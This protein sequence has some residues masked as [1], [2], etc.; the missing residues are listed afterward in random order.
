[1]NNVSGIDY[2][3]INSGAMGG[4]SGIYPSAAL[5]LVGNLGVGGM[6]GCGGGGMFGGG[7]GGCGI[8]ELIIIM[9]L[10][11]GGCGGGLFGG[12][13]NCDNGQTNFTAF[14]S[15][16]NQINGLQ[17]T[18]NSNKLDTK[19]DHIDHEICETNHH[20]DKCCCKI[21]GDIKDS[22]YATTTQFGCIKSALGEGFGAVINNADKN[23]YKII[24]TI[25]EGFAQQYAYFTAEKM[26]HKDEIIAKQNLQI[27]QAA[28]NDYLLNKFACLF[29]KKEAQPVFIVDKC[30][31]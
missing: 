27:S 11:G 29:G 23:T 10:F 6:G 22:L 20:F 12:R 13:G 17:N 3:N 24:D 15:I 31:C 4:F 5:P 7:F 18:I 16:Q 14:D 26:A 9:A 21:E 1:M 19:L 2:Q 8:L 28:Q 25:K 30:A